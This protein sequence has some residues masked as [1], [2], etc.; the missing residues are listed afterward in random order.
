MGNQDNHWASTSNVGDI[1]DQRVRETGI[2]E[3]G[4]GETGIG[5][6]DPDLTVETAK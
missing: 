3:T 2:G 1:K 6:T 5:E 4:I